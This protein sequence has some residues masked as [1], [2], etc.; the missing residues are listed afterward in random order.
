MHPKV[1]LVEDHEADRALIVEVIAEVVPA[2]EVVVCKDGREALDH[3]GDIQRGILEAPAVALLDLTMP[4][5]NGFDVLR[6]LRTHAALRRT[7]VVVFTSSDREADIDISYELRANAYVVK[8]PLG[9]DFRNVV[10]VAIEFWLHRNVR[11]N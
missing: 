6:E 11:P 8:P 3:V 4:N 7:P 2:A 9:A 5:A 1:L 10:R